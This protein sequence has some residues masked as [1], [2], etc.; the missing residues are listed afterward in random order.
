MQCTTA[1]CVYNLRLIDQDQLKRD[2]NLEQVEASYAVAAGVLRTIAFAKKNLIHSIRCT[3][4]MSANL[5][6]L[7]LESS[8]LQATHWNL[9]SLC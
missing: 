3:D 2:A 4:G 6:W 7:A 1:T 8:V 5:S 9:N